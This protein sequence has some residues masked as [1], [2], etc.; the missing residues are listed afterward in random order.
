MKCASLRKKLS[1]YADGEL[2]PEQIK[3]IDQHI[4]ECPA[5]REELN[6]INTLKKSIISARDPFISQIISQESSNL[7]NPTPLNL[8]PLIKTKLSQKQTRLKYPED[9]YEKYAYKLS[10]S[11]AMLLYLLTDFDPVT[12][13]LFWFYFLYHLVVYAQKFDLRQTLIKI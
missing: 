11:A 5:C 6:F 8:W 7:S 13:T 9:I 10:L 2:I 12:T 1:A 3:I 4:Q